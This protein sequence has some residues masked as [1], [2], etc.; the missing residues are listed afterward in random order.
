MDERIRA[1]CDL[2]VP[3]VREMAGL[4]DYDG[5][6]QD[7]SPDGVRRGLAAL[8]RAR[9]DGAPLDDPHDEAHLAVFEEA[10]RVQYADLELHRRD[11]YLHLSNL[12]LT[13]YDRE[14]APA[15]E[16]D[17]ARRR[18]LARWPET[19]DAAIA[20]LDLVT[21][22]VAAALLGAVRG[23]AAGLDAEQDAVTAAALAAHE[24]LVAHVHRA[25]A[26]GDPDPRLGAATLAA[27][28]GSQ[29]GLPADLTALAGQAEQERARLTALLT[30]ACHALA[31]HT[32]VAVTVRGLLADHPDADGV[33]PE[34][35]RLT[36]EVIDFT[37]RR[38][39]VPYLDGECLVGPAPASRRWSSA[40]LTW[41]APYEA[42]APSWY[43]VTP[44]GDDWPD[45]EREEWLTLFSR[46]GLPA[47]TVH[48]IAPGHFAHGRALRRAPTDVRR[49]LHSLGFCEGWAHYAEE[50]CL[51]EGFR[52]GDPRFAA[53]VALEALVR[54]T[55]LTCAI[56]L[57]T[58]AMDLA[59]ATERFRRDAYLSPAAA[60]SEARRGTFDAAYGRYT[61]GKLEILRLRE[62]A[63]KRWGAG[64]SLPRFHAALLRLGSPPL[65]LL[66]AAL[67]DPGQ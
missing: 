25:A 27:L 57:H 37:R 41:A 18:H 34:A 44:P 19:V 15:A 12:E 43:H 14:Y 51:E 8:A 38:G 33:I 52:D 35:A 40:M 3:V 7:L 48:E 26:A 47:V 67:D 64:F 63:R 13:A 45:E 65:G 30:E 46:A 1:V 2:T 61:W 9:R 55:R 20:A 22:P 11:P 59:E 50:M 16:R 28:M 31:P 5:V 39:L 32:P 62:R 21:A 66:P 56:G 17:R 24:R 53:G 6:V 36:A 60:A 42:D 54:V 49:T 23:L 4:H 10:V 58:G 29:E